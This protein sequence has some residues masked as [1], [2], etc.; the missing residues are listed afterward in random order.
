MIDLAL[1]GSINP[2]KEFNLRFKKDKYFK[3]VVEGIEK[4]KKLKTKP[5]SFIVKKLGMACSYPGTFESSIHAI[6]NSSDYKTAILK[7]IKAGGCN[8][9]RVNFIGA[10]FAALKGLKSIPVK[11]IN[12]TF[13]AR[14]ILNQN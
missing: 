12:K 8:C 7:T 5:H 3:S 2:I 11:W 9:S 14:K 4:V 13:A 6:I 10:Y 1:K